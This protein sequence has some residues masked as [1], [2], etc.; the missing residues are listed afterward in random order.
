MYLVESTLEIGHFKQVSITNILLKSISSISQ[1]KYIYSAKALVLNHKINSWMRSSAIQV[2]E[3][4]VREI[5]QADSYFV[6]DAT[7]Q[8][9]RD[10]F[11]PCK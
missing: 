6:N 10:Y 9:P 4:A 2:W 8:A 1:V 5:I 3:T 7:I 11:R